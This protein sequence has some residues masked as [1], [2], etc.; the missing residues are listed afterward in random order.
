MLT[1]AA[2]RVLD[3]A[4]MDF[5]DAACSGHKK[6]LLLR[7]QA[8]VNQWNHIDLMPLMQACRCAHARIASVLLAAKA[9]VNSW[10]SA[11]VTPLMFAVGEDSEDGLARLDTVN[12]L[13]LAGAYLDCYDDLGQTPLMHASKRRDL[14]TARLLLCSRASV[15]VR[16]YCGD[17]ALTK[18]QYFGNREDTELQLLQL[19]MSEL[20]HLGC[21]RLQAAED[22]LDAAVMNRVEA[23]RQLLRARAPLH[24]I[25]ERYCCRTAL[26]LACYHGATETAGLLLDARA[27]IDQWA[28]AR[29]DLWT[30]AGMT[31][32]MH[33]SGLG[34]L[35]IVGDLLRARADVNCWN[36]RGFTALMIASSR[37]HVD[38]ARRLLVATAD[39][40]AV[41][42]DGRSSLMLVCGRGRQETSCLRP[43]AGEHFEMQRLPEISVTRPLCDT[44]H[45]DVFHALL[46]GRA[47]ADRRDG[48]HGYTALMYATMYGDWELVQQ[49]LGAHAAVDMRCY[50]GETA[51]MQACANGNRLIVR[52][53]LEAAA[54]ANRRDCDG[55]QASYVARVF[56]HVGLDDILRGHR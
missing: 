24:W 13:L 27:W 2:F 49:L 7:F 28:D 43:M 10:S 17:S 36:T 4:N 19:T 16:D 5:L 39:V 30:D 32:L 31:A 51:L 44:G 48:R 53:L 1:G 33:A 11:G 56:G 8:D 6:L 34:R 23:T 25:H 21:T 47:D 22:L 15:N 42:C 18:A 3:R 35:E 20:S 12:A 9:N 37:G 45:L 54:D 52:C 50:T 46:E 41:D 40:H 38:I 55:F 14:E 26:M 29:V